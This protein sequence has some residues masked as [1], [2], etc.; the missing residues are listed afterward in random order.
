MW[1]AASRS[2]MKA[3][4]RYAVAEI[5]WDACRINQRHC[6]VE[7]NPEESTLAGWVR[8]SIFALPLLGES[9]GL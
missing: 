6:L 2:V 3:P 7:I 5:G 1:L 8:L 4:T 9:A